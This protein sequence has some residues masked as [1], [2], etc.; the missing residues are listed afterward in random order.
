VRPIADIYTFKPMHQPTF[1]R[2]INK[3]DPGAFLRS[4]RHNRIEL[5]ADSPFQ[6]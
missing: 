6:E 4:T 1:N 3:P 2:Q 5:F